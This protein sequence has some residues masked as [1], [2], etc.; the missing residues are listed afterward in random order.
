MNRKDK[1]AY[2]IEAIKLKGLKYEVLNENGG[3]PNHIRV[4]GFGDIW[5]TSATFKQG[6]TITRK[7]LDLL[8][9]KLGLDKPAVKKEKSNREIIISQD[10]RLRL[11]EERICYLEASIS[12][13]IE[14]SEGL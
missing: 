7:N 3:I 8:I 11:L 2:I 5:P 14:S 13:L 10:K 12:R 9:Q 4:S 1:A 6:S